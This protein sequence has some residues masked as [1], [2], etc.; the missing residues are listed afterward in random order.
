M[1]SYAYYNGQFGKRDEIK[2]PLSDRSIFFGDAV[3]DTAIGCYDRILWEIEHIER[4]LCNAQRLGIEHK[5][6]MPTK[7][8]DE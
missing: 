8:K 4:L 6:P 1:T 3:Y 2:I 7:W 5:Y